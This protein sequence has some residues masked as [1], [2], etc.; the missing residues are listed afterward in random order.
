MTGW[1]PI[2]W[3]AA[4][5]SGCSLVLDGDNRAGEGDGGSEDCE[6][7]VSDLLL[8][9]D[10]ASVDDEVVGFQ[11][12]SANVS[13]PPR[14]ALLSRCP[15]GTELVSDSAA[16][17]VEAPIDDST[18]LVVYPLRVPVNRERAGE[19]QQ[20]SL[21]A[22]LGGGTLA[23]RTVQVEFL[24]E[25]FASEDPAA[26]SG[27]YSLIVVGPS[28]ELTGDGDQ[29]IRLVSRSAVIVFGT[30]EVSATGQQGGAGGFAGG[31]PTEQGEGPGGGPGAEDG[32]LTCLGSGGSHAELG[33]R[34]RVGTTNL[35]QGA[36][37][38]EPHLLDTVSGRGGSGGGGC[39]SGSDATAGG[40]GGGYVEIAA[41]GAMVGG[42]VNGGSIRAAGVSGEVF[43]TTV[44]GGSGA[45]GAIWVRA[46]RYLGKL[47]LDARGGGAD[48]ISPNG[49]DGWLRIDSVDSTEIAADTTCNSVSADVCLLEARSHHR[50]AVLDIPSLIAG[51]SGVG[52][53]VGGAEAPL[54][55]V[56][57]G[58]RSEIEAAGDASFDLDLVPGLHEICVVYDVMP[59]GLETSE[60]AIWR[61][62]AEHCVEAAVL[63]D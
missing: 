31:N 37:Y 51:D 10:G 21:A 44:S 49:G 12:F 2:V 59:A 22:R 25:L 18:E 34:G 45:G 19:S 32:G 33:S 35:G 53:I 28:A 63:P 48:T 57:D 9:G 54:F 15:A 16:V 47:V 7:L 26:V 52:A 8:E 30:V 29:P 46:E 4:V 17:I 42:P 61:R 1:A 13:S 3:L 50:G 43:S 36:S 6:I 39:T 41:A 40:G 24:R 23:E 5:A 56:V 27:L 62:R 14:L 11:I 20:V 58:A 55:L 60:E 38:G